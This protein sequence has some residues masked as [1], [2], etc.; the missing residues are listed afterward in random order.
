MLFRYFCL[1]SLH[2]GHTKC[3]PPQ[4]ILYIIQEFYK[5]SLRELHLHFVSIY[6]AFGYDLSAY[7]SCENKQLDDTYVVFDKNCNADTSHKGKLTRSLP[8]YPSC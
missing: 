3:I 1:K 8:L 2:R 5:Q 4:N 6:L 7:F